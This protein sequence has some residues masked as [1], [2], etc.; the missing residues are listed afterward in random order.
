MIPFNCLTVPLGSNNTYD[1]EAC[2]D[3]Y[4]KSEDIEGVEC[5]SCTLIS[6]AAKLKQ[7]QLPVELRG[8]IAERLQAI[9]Q[10]LDSDDFSDKTLK[11]DCHILPKAFVNSTKTKELVLGRAPQSLVV[12]I[13]RSVFD[14]MT[15]SQRKNYA[16]VRFPFVLDLQEWM[17]SIGDASSHYQLS[18]VVTHYGRHENGHYICYRRH[19][20]LE[21]ADEHEDLGHDKRKESWWRLSDEDV[22][23]V[24]ETEV[25]DQGGVFMLFYERITEPGLPHATISSAPAEVVEEAAAIPLPADGADDWDLYPGKPSSTATPSLVTSSEHSVVSESDTDTDYDDEDPTVAKQS[26]Q[27][28]PVLKTASPTSL[29]PTQKDMKHAIGMSNTMMSV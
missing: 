1:L 25:L 8:Q 12:H 10:A 20:S 7:L 21:T 6:A 9:E 18:A 11:Q 22:S 29:R 16:N 26:S 19:A 23:P 15:G 13:N 2:L 4:T 17:L 24:T 5:R 3:E 28:T 27:P 14:P